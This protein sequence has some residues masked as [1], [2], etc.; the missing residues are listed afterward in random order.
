MR[1]MILCALLLLGLPAAEA[2]PDA[3]EQKL[4]SGARGACLFVPAV[5]DNQIII[6]GELVCAGGVS[7]VGFNAGPAGAK[8]YYCTLRPL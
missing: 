4:L 5:E 6:G 3:C 2:A 7:H 8:A 1:G